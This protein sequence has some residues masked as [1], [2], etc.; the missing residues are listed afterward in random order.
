MIPALF[1][2][3]LS[4]IC[5]NCIYVENANVTVYA[6]ELGEESGNCQAPCDLTSYMEPL[7]YDVGV[8]CGPDIPYGTAVI[9]EGVGVRICNDH[10]GAIDNDEVDVL[11]RAEDYPSWISGNRRV[12]WIEP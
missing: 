1:I 8:A 12:I 9:I 6:P 10:G 3:L 4:S 7:Q 5:P 11:I 2:L